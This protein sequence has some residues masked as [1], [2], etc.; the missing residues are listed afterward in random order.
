MKNFRLFIILLLTTSCKSEIDYVRLFHN[1][2]SNQ[3]DKTFTVDNVNYMQEMNNLFEELAKEKGFENDDKAVELRNYLITIVDNGFN[4]LEKN[5]LTSKFRSLRTK[6]I[7]IGLLDNVEFLDIDYNYASESFFNGKI[8]LPD[9]KYVYNNGVNPNFLFKIYNPIYLKYKKELDIANKEKPDLTYGIATSE[10]DQSF[11][12]VP[13][14][15]SILTQTNIK[16]FSEPSI[17]K[18]IILIVFGHQISLSYK[19]DFKK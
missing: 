11:S 15:G 6:L 13:V 18:S 1:E 10:E 3:I 7:K 14:V 5:H 2:I 19:L 4:N 8:R 17:R 16:D 12:I 9:N